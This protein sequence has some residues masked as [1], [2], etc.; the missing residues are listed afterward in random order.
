M[1]NVEFEN[2]EIKELYKSII[3][4]H[5]GLP[6]IILDL[7][8]NDKP[9]TI[10]DIRQLDNGIMILIKTNNQ[11]I[12]IEID[13]SKNKILVGRN[14]KTYK[15]IYDDLPLKNMKPIGYLYQ[16]DTR[17]ITKKVLFD[18]VSDKEKVRH[19]EINENGNHYTLILKIKNTI[20][21]EEE[22]IIKLLNST[23]KYNSIRDLFISIT[24]FID[25]NHVDVSIGDAKG[26]VISIRLY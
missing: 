1:N 5:R 3:K 20:F 18:L 9:I 6:S 23:S 19:F 10:T 17:E 25:I 12:D 2:D 11:F 15:E 21:N 4:K 13:H 22:T 16:K 14:H 24:Q 26:S 7:V 8:K